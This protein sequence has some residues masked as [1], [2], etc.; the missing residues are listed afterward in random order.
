MLVNR[1]H[2]NRVKL[3]AKTRGFRSISGKV[4]RAVS[5]APT[6]SIEFYGRARGVGR[7]GG[8]GRWIASAHRGRLWL[9]TILIDIGSRVTFLPRPQIFTCNSFSFAFHPPSIGAICRW[10]DAF[11]HA[12]RVAA[13]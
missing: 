12:S 3:V 1:V 6:T 11:D 8:G 7:G 5:I 10:G 13:A 2:E 9:V 4:E